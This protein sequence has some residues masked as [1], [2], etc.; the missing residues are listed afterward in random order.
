M[1]QLTKDRLLREQMQGLIPRRS[2]RLPGWMGEL[3]LLACVAALIASVQPWQLLKPWIAPRDANPDTEV[4]GQNLARTPAAG[5]ASPGAT[6]R[7]VPAT[8]GSSTARLVGTLKSPAAS[9]PNQADGK[10]Q[11]SAESPDLV[12]KSGPPTGSGNQENATEQTVLRTEVPTPEDR[13]AQAEELL[14]D[15][16]KLQ[17]GVDALL[18]RL[19][20]QRR[21]HVDGSNVLPSGILQDLE[22]QLDQLATLGTRLYEVEQ[23][24]R[25]LPS[26]CRDPLGQNIESRL[27]RLT[28]RI[29]DANV[30]LRFG[31][32]LSKAIDWEFTQTKQAAEHDAQES[33]DALRPAVPPV[34]G[35]PSSNRAA[36]PNPATDSPPQAAPRTEPA[37]TRLEPVA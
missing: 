3:L 25:D 36:Q 20:V 28:G 9:P 22:L 5:A 31:A 17:D 26:V 24:D 27:A 23:A 19:E 8:A 14:L 10:D 35:K 7:A 11:G 6:P 33:D 30:R 13:A 34:P 21:Q 16:S 18:T 15:L 12:A 29:Q 1:D 4:A 2:W 32:A 37:L